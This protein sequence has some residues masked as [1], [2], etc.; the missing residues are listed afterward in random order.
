MVSS[1]REIDARHGVNEL[2]GSKKSSVGRLL[3]ASST[4]KLECGASKV[5]PDGSEDPERVREC[6]AQ[7]E[8]YLTSRTSRR[9]RVLAKEATEA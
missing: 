1:A 3:R 6:H 4:I 5:G 7:R 2:A 9:G 8:E